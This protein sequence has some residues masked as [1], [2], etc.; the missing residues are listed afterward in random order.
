MDEE[1]EDDFYEPSPLPSDA[2][3]AAAGS[4]ASQQRP[5]DSRTAN[6]MAPTN[7]VKSVADLEEGEEKDEGEDE[8]G[9]GEEGDESD[10][11]VLASLPS[12]GFISSV[13]PQHLTYPIV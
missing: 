7:E 10:D 5:G 1:G 13:H 8:D 3:D 11:S 4:V 2:V 6:I 12:L 9:D